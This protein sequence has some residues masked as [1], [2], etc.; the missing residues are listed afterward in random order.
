MCVCVFVVKFSVQFHNIILV[1]KQLSVC[2]FGLNKNVCLLKLQLFLLKTTLF[3]LC[4][5]SE[6]RS[7]RETRPG[8]DRRDLTGLPAT[9]GRKQS[10]IY[11]RPV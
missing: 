8:D 1:A 6:R 9:R 5:Y 4:Y 2:R 7:K 10:P 3:M 11:I